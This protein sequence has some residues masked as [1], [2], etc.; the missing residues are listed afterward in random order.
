MGIAY[1]RGDRAP[2]RT[3]S[4]VARRRVRAARL[5]ADRRRRLPGR[6]PQCARS[7]ADGAGGL[8]G[9]AD[10]QR[11]ATRAQ[12]R[13]AGADRTAPATDAANAARLRKRRPG[14]GAGTGRRRS[15]GRFQRDPPAEGADGRRGART[16]GRARCLDPRQ[17]QVAACDRIARHTAWVGHDRGRIPAAVG[18]GPWPKRRPPMPTR[19]CMPASPGSS[20]TVPTCAS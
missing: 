16:A 20:A 9:A 6:L 1:Q 7:A 4:A 11:F 17:R 18:A 8:V 13:S 15:D 10:R 3:G 14:R 12:R 2:G 19:S 5:P